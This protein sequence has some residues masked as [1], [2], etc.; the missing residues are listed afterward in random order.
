MTEAGLGP[1]CFSERLATQYRPTHA[2]NRSC[3]M[4]RVEIHDD[5]PFAYRDFYDVPRLLL[6]CVGEHRLLLDCRFD[7]GLDEYAE[8]YE[9]YKLKDGFVAPQ[10]TWESILEHAHERLGIVPVQQIQFDLT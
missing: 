9:V 8:I 4:S 1:S 3:P 5:L 2:S 7:S 6:V 10:G